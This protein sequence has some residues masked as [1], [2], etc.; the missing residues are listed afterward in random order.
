[1]L[2]QEEIE[3]FKRDWYSFEEIKRIEDSLKHFE[4]TW[5]SYDID[6]AFEIVNKQ[7]FSKYMVS[8]SIK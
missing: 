3:A 7:I 6:E 1:M 5:I 8:W 4:E 2:S